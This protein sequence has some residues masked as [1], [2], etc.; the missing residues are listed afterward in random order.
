M[1]ETRNPKKSGL[2]VITFE[3]GESNPVV[4]L[5]LKIRPAPLPR[6]EHYTGVEHP[7]D[8]RKLTTRRRNVVNTEDRKKKLDLCVPPIRARGVEPLLIRRVALKRHRARV[9][10]PSWTH[11]PVLT[12]SLSGVQIFCFWWARA[13]TPTRPS[14]R[15]RPYIFAGCLLTGMLLLGYT[16]AVAGVVFAR[17]RHARGVLTIVFATVAIFLIDFAIN[18]VQAVDRALLVDMLPP[19]Q[20]AAGNAC[21][22]LMLNTGSVVGFF[23]GN[24]D[25]HTLLPFLRADSELQTSI[26]TAKSSLRARAPKCHTADFVHRHIGDQLQMKLRAS[27]SSESGPGVSATVEFLSGISTRVCAKKRT[28]H[29]IPDIFDDFPMSLGFFDQ[30][31]SS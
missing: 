18:G 11:L 25:L 1:N 31:P 29:L 6:A 7:R 15:S 26:S 4:H 17:G 23:F 5:H 30:L 10:G 3:R 12:I 28:F 16:H 21:A 9:F 2:H 13:R 27:C 24:L 22:A 14:G 8:F 20:Q 19:E